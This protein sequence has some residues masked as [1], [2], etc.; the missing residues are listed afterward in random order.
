LPKH[1]S[2][3]DSSNRQPKAPPETLPEIKAALVEAQAV[4]DA[5]HLLESTLFA[6]AWES[7]PERVRRAVAVVRERALALAGGLVR[8]SA[9]AERLAVTAEA[10]II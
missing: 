5:A 9:A 10:R 7:S 2:V 3:T 1:R 6:L 8:V 4:L